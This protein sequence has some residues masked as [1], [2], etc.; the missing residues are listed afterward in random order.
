M[1]AFSSRYQAVSN[2]EGMLHAFFD[3]DNAHVRSFKECYI[4]IT[5]D[6]KCTGRV[7]DIDAARFGEMTGFREA[8]TT[9]ALA[10]VLSSAIRRRM[11]ADYQ[12][13]FSRWAVW[14]KIASIARDVTDFRT[15]ERTR[16]GGYGDLP[17]V[18]QGSSY[19]ALTP[20]TDDVATYSVQKRGGTEDITLEAIRADNSELIRSIP[21]KLADTAHRTASKFVLD[22]IRTNP[23]IYDNLPLYHAQHQNSGSAPLSAVSLAAGINAMRAQ[24]E[25]GSGDRLDL[26]PRS[27]LVPFDGEETAFNLFRRTTNQDKTFIQ[28]RKIEIVP[29]WYWTDPNDW[30]LVADPAE[31][32][33]IELAFLDGQEDPEVFVADN[34]S[35]GSLFSHDKLVF[36]IRHIYGGTVVDYRGIYKSTVP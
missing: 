24:R 35:A 6:R 5:G 8:L 21:K 17:E 10:N 14:R 23:V 34:P 33:V 2:A 3:P 15:Q 18:S 4:A 28:S 16:W 9:D 7:E 20:P 11:I 25:P 19:P 32:P 30:A 12:N 36:K 29:I 31:A 13:R 27:L 26:Q 22:L 1:N